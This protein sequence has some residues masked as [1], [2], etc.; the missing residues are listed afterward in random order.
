MS[1]LSEKLMTLACRLDDISRPMVIVGQAEGEWRPITGQNLHDAAKK[2]HAISKE[3]KE[4]E[5]ELETLKAKVQDV[6]DL[7]AS[8]ENTNLIPACFNEGVGYCQHM[9]K[10]NK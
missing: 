5:E 1:E 10:G 7:D 4:R 3:V 2:I 9:L 6:L 8:E